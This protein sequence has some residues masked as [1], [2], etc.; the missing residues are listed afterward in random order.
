MQESGPIWI[1]AVEAV[2]ALSGSLAGVADAFVTTM[3]S[4]ARGPLRGGLGDAAA[5]LVEGVASCSGLEAA[6]EVYQRLMR[7]P[8]PGGSF[9]QQVGAIV[10]VGGLSNSGVWRCRGGRWN[11]EGNFEMAA[12]FVLQIPFPSLSPMTALHKGSRSHRLELVC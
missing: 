9:F 12:Y 11:F 1:T 7:G 8:A 6:R 2:T 5:S 4:Q 10:Y 3:Q